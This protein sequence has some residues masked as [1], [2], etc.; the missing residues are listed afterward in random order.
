MVFPEGSRSEDNHIKRFHKGAFYLAETFNLDIIPVLIHGNSEVLPKGDFI[1]NDGSITV[2][3]ME[4]IT[5][6]DIRFGENYAERT[7][8]INHFF[9]E[10]FA[11]M[12]SQI[13]GVNYFKKMILHSFA[14]KEMEIISEVKENLDKKLQFFNKKE[15]GNKVRIL[16]ISNDYGETDLLLALQAPERKIYSF[17]ASEEKRDV[18]KTNYIVRKRKINYLD[19]KEEILQNKYDVLLISTENELLTEEFLTNFP[20]IIRAI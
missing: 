2:E 12:R 10:S 20:Q 4:R 11:I 14:Y 3:I 13:E 9:R 16:H 1:I 5:P 19:T 15:I 17:I 18:A 7:K 6:N 8:K